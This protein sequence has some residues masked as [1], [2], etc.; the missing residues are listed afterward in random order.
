MQR[1]HKKKY[2]PDWKGW[3]LIDL[4]RINDKQYVKEL[5]KDGSPVM[6]A[7]YDY[8][9]EDVWCELELD[10]FPYIIAF[11]I[12]DQYI[13]LGA[14]RMGKFV[15]RVLNGMNYQNM[16]GEDL[17]VDGVIGKNSKAR[18]R[19]I[20][21]DNRT[22]AFVL[23]LNGLQANHYLTRTEENKTQRKWFVGWLKRTEMQQ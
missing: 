16:Y 11:E 1:H 10:S 6:K 7:T 15:Q 14:G 3:K 18:I 8:Y 2:Q 13:N 23:A 4:S 5:L 17:K 20:V 9:Y 12:F 22:K 19:A 21:A